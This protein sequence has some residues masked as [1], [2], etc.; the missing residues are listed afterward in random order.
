MAATLVNTF[1]VG[2]P[3]IANQPFAFMGTNYKLGRRFPYEDLKMEPGQ[4]E[5]L[6]G[7]KL[8]RFVA[9][10][11]VEL[12]HGEG[13]FTQKQVDALVA[14]EVAKQIDDR[15]K[16]A[17]TKAVAAA[18]AELDLVT[19]RDVDPKAGAGKLGPIPRTP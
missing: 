7:A 3:A 1:A 6:Y 8:I 12:K 14:A 5:Q 17:V 18:R 2:Q 13:L 11:A 10:K 16:E 9:G 15:V 19:A 4:L